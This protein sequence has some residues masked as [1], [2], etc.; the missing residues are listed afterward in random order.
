MK[1]LFVVSIAAVHAFLLGGVFATI[2]F[3]D[4]SGDANLNSGRVVIKYENNLIVADI[5]K[6]PLSVVVK[7]I[8]NQTGAHFI[9][10]DS[11]I[12][13][14]PLSVKISKATFEEA[15]KRI[16]KHYS[17]AAYF[18]SG[19]NVNK[20]VVFGAKAGAPKGPARHAVNSQSS[21]STS[22]TVHSASAESLIKEPVRSG[23]V[24]QPLTASQQTNEEGQYNTE[25]E[26]LSDEPSP[27]EANVP[28]DLDEYQ[29]LT[30]ELLD[31][32]V[33][34]LGSEQQDPEAVRLEAEARTA[35]AERLDQER[36]ERS[37]SALNSEHAHLRSMAVE[38]L[39]PLKDPR[40]TT[41]LANV[42][43]SKDV[44]VDERRRAAQALWHHAADSQFSDS[45]ANQALAQLAGE[46]DPAVRD[47]ARRAL[48]DMERYQ[49]RNNR[50]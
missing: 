17:Y 43:S 11:S 34:D 27:E 2:A 6:A 22:G 29:S 39:V 32:S 28:Y 45:A 46:G 37:L 50:Y 40:A 13:N 3:A 47:I 19:G 4:S 24:S 7:K 9:L 21:P 38:E 48:I 49:R 1:K 35:R 31:E 36:L 18:D 33:S 12:V 5:D 44:S 16:F 15:L 25:R 14:Y 23:D 26:D 8:E 42:A 41:A 20:V 30:E 10:K